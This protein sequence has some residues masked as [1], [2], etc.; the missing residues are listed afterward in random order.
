MKV[1]CLQIDIV[2]GKPSQNKENVQTE[3]MRVMKFSPDVI[4]LPELWS[5]GYDLT[6]IAEIAD[7][8]GSD[9]KKFIS[10]LARKY[11]VNIVAGS[12]AKKTAGKTF[13]TMY[14]FNR[15]GEYVA[16]YSK[17][18][19]F[20]LMDEHLYLQHGNSKGLFTV[21]GVSSAGLICY[22]IRFPEWVRSHATS[23]AEIIFVVAQWPLMR[24]EHW[25]TLLK[26]RA[27]ENQCYIVACNRVGSDPNNEF[28]GHSLIIDPWGEI[29]AEANL[30]VMALTATIDLEKVA[31]VRKQIPIFDDR[32]PELY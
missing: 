2:Y 15:S 3:I 32:R 16:E 11:Q 22:D 28:A 19:L 4:V 30:Q 20:K 25:R 29:L 27:I 12:I 23:G 10:R 9:T 13:N 26:S 14:I 7:L 5:T 24:L 31:S 17:A 18:H 1:A 21:D 8:E 6:R